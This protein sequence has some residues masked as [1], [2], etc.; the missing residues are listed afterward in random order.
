[1]TPEQLAEEFVGE[2]LRKR[3]KGEISTRAGE[4]KE[5]KNSE[6]IEESRR[7]LDEIYEAEQ[8]ETLK[9]KSTADMIAEADKQK[10]N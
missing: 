6:K 2:E 9:G 1:M 5:E 7:K 8:S 3:M 4:T 10:K